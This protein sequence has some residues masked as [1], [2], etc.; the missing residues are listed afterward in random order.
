MEEEA[1]PL[2]VPEVLLL[3]LQHL[4]KLCYCLVCCTRVLFQ[5][6]FHVFLL[7]KYLFYR[8]SLHLLVFRINIIHSLLE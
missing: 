3:L 6:C 7:F 8:R 2:E 4:L 1:L 5:P